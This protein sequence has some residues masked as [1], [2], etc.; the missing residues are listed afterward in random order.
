MEALLLLTG[1]HGAC[2]EF[3]K[4]VHAIERHLKGQFG[5]RRVSGRFE[6]G[7]TASLAADDR[8][9]QQCHELG[10]QRE[11]AAHELRAV[12]GDEIFLRVDEDVC[13]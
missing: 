13:W 4:P 11:V 3:P 2:E 7:R 5:E 1:L 6:A 12:D 10:A 9:V 8:L